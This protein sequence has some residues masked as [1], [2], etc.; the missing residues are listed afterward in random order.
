MLLPVR[1][2]QLFL[3]YNETITLAVGVIRTFFYLLIRR[4]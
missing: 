4:H 2:I 1:F 3:S